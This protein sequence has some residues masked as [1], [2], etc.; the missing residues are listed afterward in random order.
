MDCSP[1]GSSVHRISQAR[2]LERVA[3]FLLGGNLPDPGIEPESSASPTLAGGFFSTEI[4]G[5]PLLFP[6]MWIKAAEAR[7]WGSDP[8]SSGW[9][10]LHGRE[11]DLE[12]TVRCLPV[13]RKGTLMKGV[14]VCYVDITARGITEWK[15]RQ[16]INSFPLAY[17]LMTTSSYIH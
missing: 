3:I 16:R 4:P 13:I 7:M 5:K 8:K 10:L 12:D 14:R 9:N 6:C 2:I 11:W 1:P 17:G 15:G